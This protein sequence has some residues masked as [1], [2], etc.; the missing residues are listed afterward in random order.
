[1]EQEAP[2]VEQVPQMQETAPLEPPESALEVSETIDTGSDEERMVQ[3]LFVEPAPAAD[4][5]RPP[6][7]DLLAEAS[8]PSMK[9]QVDLPADAHEQP[10]AAESFSGLPALESV[11]TDMEYVPGQEA[12]V[13]T[14]PPSISDTISETWPDTMP[15]PA[16]P[17]SANEYSVD[18]L[19][20]EEPDF[21]SAA[22]VP[23]PARPSL[24]RLQSALTGELVVDDGGAVAQGPEEQLAPLVEVD[25]SFPSLRSAETAELPLDAGHLARGDFPSLRSAETSELPLETAYS[26]RD[27]PASSEPL[28]LPE[29]EQSSSRRPT[30]VTGPHSPAERTAARQD[31][32][33]ADASR[34][35]IRFSSITEAL[36][37]DEDARTPAPAGETSEEVG[38][39]SMDEG[40]FEFVF[41]DDEVSAEYRAAKE[42]EPPP[43]PPPVAPTR[44][45]SA[46][47]LNPLRPSPSAHLRSAHGPLIKPRE[48]ALPPVHTRQRTA[49]TAQ[50]TTQPPSV[51][52][53]PPAPVKPRP[54][55][56]STQRFKS[57]P[58]GVFPLVGGAPL[59]R[60]NPKS[61]T[62]V[63]EDAGPL[64]RRPSSLLRYTAPTRSHSRIEA[65]DEA[66]QPDQAST[67]PRPHTVSPR[68]RRPRVTTKPLESGQKGTATGSSVIV[69]RPVMVGEGKSAKPK[70]PTSSAKA[71][72]PTPRGT[73]RYSYSKIKQVEIATSEP[74]SQ[75]GEEDR[76][77][78]EV[79]LAYLEEAE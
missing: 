71:A 61:Q 27:A 10:Q 3:E 54:A 7:A 79:I 47:P 57:R 63:A 76:G 24:H 56:R 15:R 9:L 25:D 31:S 42:P 77:L 38:G 14:E 60:F 30:L 65:R 23:P 49:D 74:A 29:R 68:R 45:L 28:E 16:A 59:R 75:G 4:E 20:T 12:T 1:M 8:T 41:G 6:F 11:D 21:A 37:S 72:P 2:L 43:P 44:E 17:A 40:V 51:S 58:S 36:W 33:A 66:Q 46:R 67:P 50:R 69:T 32:A 35:T 19:I 13:P 73:G 70:V 34:D 39:E 55:P 48:P 26:L 5:F 53:R 22:A 78:D 62:P 52:L 18:E 64:R